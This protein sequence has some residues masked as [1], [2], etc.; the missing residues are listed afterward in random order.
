MPH[1]LLLLPLLFLWA[2]LTSACA[3][4]DLI[5]IYLT[6]Q[7]DPTT[8]MT[9]NWV[10]LYERTPASLWYRAAGSEEWQSKSGTRGAME[11]STL[12][13]RRVEL[14]GLLPGTLYEF[15]LAEKAP[16]DS[17]G[18]ERFRTMPADLTQPVRFVT[19]GDMMHSREYVDTMNK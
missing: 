1:R 11:P 6:W 10:N 13:V 12:Q 19:G 2:T 16:K 8:T 5:G 17:K 7:R 9:V 15:S 18:V 14:T 4:S 3:Q